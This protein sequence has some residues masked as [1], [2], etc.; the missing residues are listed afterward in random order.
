MLS[1]YYQAESY[2]NEGL[3]R[4]STPDIPNKLTRREW[5]LKFLDDLGHPE[6]SFPAIH[7]AGTSGKGSTAIM[8]AEILRASGHKVGLHTTPYLQ[9]ATEKLWFDGKYASSD[10][11]IELVEWIRPICEKWRRPEVPLHGMASFGICLEYFRR[12]R[13]DIAVIE[14][15]V[16]GR[17][18]LTNVLNTK[19]SVITP[20][21]I[22]H[23]VT[24]GESIKSIA[25]HKAGIIKSKVPV[26]AYRGPGEKIIAAV[27][28]KKQ[29]T[30]YWVEDPVDKPCAM[31]GR[32]QEINA[33]LAIKAAGAIG[34]MSTSERDTGLRK[35][36]LPG[37][38]EILQRN[39]KVIID[40]AHNYQKLSTLFT[41]FTDSEPTI[42]FGILGNK[43]SPDV[44]TLLN[45]INGQLILTTP[46]VYGKEPAKLH[47]LV[48]LLNNK[49]THITGNPSDALKKA[50][51][52]TPKDGT[53]LITGSL[54][55]AGNIR[56]KYY[57]SEKVLQ[58]RASWPNETIN[59]TN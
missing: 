48:R 38:V 52:L 36:R 7:I 13:V 54:Y 14:T 11:F 31:Q 5:M 24:L 19:L 25:G 3:I 43:V 57:P 28:K 1:E 44:A 45:E 27:A 37:R 34:P 40:G 56:E 26:V 46:E 30:L 23:I 59:P 18:D 6:Q 10:E 21:G 49:N 22:D 41:E 12:K 17:D 53:I 33:A 55:L 16:G 32:F 2:I 58:D 35:A 39:P 4:T 29:A 47:D 50:L 20:L 15:G 42:V 9:V 51:Q 8:I